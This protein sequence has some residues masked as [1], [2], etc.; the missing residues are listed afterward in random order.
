MNRVPCPPQSDPDKFH[1]VNCWAMTD[2]NIK[3]AII[4]VFEYTTVMNPNIVTV[5]MP[6]HEAPS[7]RAIYFLDKTTGS[8][9]YFDKDGKL[10]GKLWSG[11]AFKPAKISEMLKQPEVKIITDLKTD[12]S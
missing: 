1:R 6:M 11:A 2:R 8:A 3:E 4:K 12:E 9:L 7:Q 5:E 10:A